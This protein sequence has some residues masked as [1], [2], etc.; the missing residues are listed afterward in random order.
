MQIA[1]TNSMIYHD[2]LP[3]HTP[4]GNTTEQRT[5]LQVRRAVALYPKSGQGNPKQNSGRLKL[6]RVLEASFAGSQ[7]H[8]A[9]QGGDTARQVHHTCDCVARPSITP[10]APLP[11]KSM[12]PTSNTVESQ[13]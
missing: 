12:N 11:A 5:C 13:P 3:R 4:G 6:L 2:I 8:S 10:E 9:G 7:D 1:N